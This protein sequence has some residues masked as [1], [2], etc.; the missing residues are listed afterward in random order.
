MLRNILITSLLVS[1][2]LGTAEAVPPWNNPARRTELRQD[3]RQQ[4]QQN[5]K[6]VK[7]PLSDVLENHYLQRNPDERQE[8]FSRRT[9]IA[10]PSTAR[11]PKKAVRDRDPDIGT[12]YYVPT[13]P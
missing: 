8:Y 3:L 6:A 13:Q 4:R 11:G 9:I 1:P 5:D 10:R 2:L 12:Y 7:P